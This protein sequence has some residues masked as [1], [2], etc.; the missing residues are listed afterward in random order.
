MGIIIRKIAVDAQKQRKVN[1]ISEKV[2]CSQSCVS[3]E[4][5]AGLTRG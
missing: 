5:L 3:S 1:L 4:R 2:F